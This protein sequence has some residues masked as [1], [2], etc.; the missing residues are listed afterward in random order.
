VEVR[1]P[2]TLVVKTVKAWSLDDRIPMGG[3]VSITL[4][5]RQ[6]EDD[7][8]LWTALSPCRSGSNR[9]GGS[10]HKLTSVDLPHPEYKL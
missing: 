5:V 2:N 9:T 10:L 7:I 4:V 1:E 6:H 8:R 3:D